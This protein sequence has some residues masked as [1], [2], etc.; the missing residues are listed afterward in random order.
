MEKFVSNFFGYEMKIVVRGSDVY[1]KSE[2]HL[3]PSMRSKVRGG[4]WEKVSN[5]TFRYLTVRQWLDQLEASPHD[6]AGAPR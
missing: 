4:K 1:T 3:S 2:P 5:Y 6:F